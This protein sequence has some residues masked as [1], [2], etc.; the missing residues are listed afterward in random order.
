MSLI[1][2]IKLKEDVFSLWRRI[3]PESAP[4]RDGLYR[5]PFRDEKKES[6]SIFDSGRRFKDHGTG[7]RGDVIDMAMILWS[8]DKKEAVRRLHDG[9]TTLPP[10]PAKRIQPPRIIDRE[11]LARLTKQVLGDFRVEKDSVTS[12]FLEARKIPVSI[13]RI[14]NKEGSLGEY[15]GAPSYVFDDGIKVRYDAD[16]SRSTRWLIGNAGG[17]PWRMR[18]LNSKIKTIILTESESDA[19]KSMSA[20][21]SLDTRTVRVIAAPSASWRPE[22]EIL[23]AITKDRRLIVATDNDDAG[24]ALTQWLMRR[25]ESC[26]PFPWDMAWEFGD[27]CELDTRDISSIFES[28]TSSPA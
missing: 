1:A 10:L 12:R 23:S 16:T 3:N 17:V 19:M 21:Q 9:S 20:L 8:C 11:K 13:A 24:R 5:S 2:E 4:C 22:P 7:D 25:V 6:F 15:N 28:L 27:L 14:L 26:I 18:T